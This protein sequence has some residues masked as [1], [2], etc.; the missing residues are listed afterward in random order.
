MDAK[1]FKVL[2]TINILQT[3]YQNYP[4]KHL[5]VLQCQSTSKQSYQTTTILY[6]LRAK[7]RHISYITERTWFFKASPTD[8]WLAIVVNCINTPTNIW[9]SF[10]IKLLAQ[11]G[12]HS[13]DHNLGIVSDNKRRV[14]AQLELSTLNCIF[15]K[16]ILKR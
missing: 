13:I 7:L 1:F 14:E 12:Y 15:R 8:S 10:S 9:H 5:I 3:I 11:Q 16:N 4:N 6:S 2:C